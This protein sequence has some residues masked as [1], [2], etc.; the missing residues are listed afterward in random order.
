MRSNDTFLPLL[1][2]GEPNAQ[3]SSLGTGLRLVPLPKFAEPLDGRAPRKVIYLPGRR[4]N[5]VV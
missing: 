1:A 2:N 3:A 5:V 4:V